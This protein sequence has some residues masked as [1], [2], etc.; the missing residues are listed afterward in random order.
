MGS[1]YMRMDAG[2]RV[3]RKSLLLISLFVVLIS[4]LFVCIFLSGFSVAFL[5]NVV[6]VKNET[7]LKNAIDNAPTGRSVTIALDNDIQLTDYALTIPRNKDVTLTSNRSSG[8]Y[9]LI[10][11]THHA[12]LVVAGG[13]LKIDGIIVSGGGDSGIHVDDG[14]LVMYDGEIS[15]NTSYFYSGFNPWG[16]AGKGGG[17]YIDSGVF[18]MYGGK[19]SNNRAQSYGGGISVGLG[20]AVIR[21]FG[22][23]ISG[24]TAETGGGGGVVCHRYSNFTMFGGTISGNTAKYGG[25]VYG[26]S[27]GFIWF[28]GVVSGNTATTGECNDVYPSGS[29]GSSNG[30]GSG[31]GGSS[32]GSGGGSGGNGSGGGS[33]SGGSGGSSNGGGGFSLGSVRHWFML[34]GSD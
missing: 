3:F 31:D 22:G 20:E 8:F 18:E 32:N 13:V 28:G 1:G 11:T 5:E 29:G 9:K 33:W 6:H 10:G 4:S 7:E 30:S 24:N 23:E 19:I 21:M 2:C 25:G 15:D 34:L 17:V 14:V 12:T 16:Y 26:S 27:D